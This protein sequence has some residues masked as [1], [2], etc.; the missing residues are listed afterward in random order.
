MFDILFKNIC[1]VNPEVDCPVIANAYVGVRDGKIAYLS[2]TETQDIAARVI[3][4]TDKALI[5]GL[6]NTHTHAAM[7][8]LRGYADDHN[9]QDWLH[10]YVFPAE[11]KLDEECVY[12]GTQLAIAEMIR[13]GTVSITDMY[14]YIPA[15][16]KAAYETG[17]YANITN[18]ALVFDRDGYR[19]EKDNSYIQMEQLRRDWHNIDNGRIKLDSGIHAE[20]TSFERVWRDYADYAKQYGLNM[21]LHLSETKFEHDSC[22][23]KYG[24]TPARVLCDAGVFDTRTTAAHCVWLTLEDMDILRDKGVT[25]AHNPV[26]NLKLA[27]GIARVSDMLSRGVNVAL[28]TDGVCSNNSHDMFE[29][30]KLCALLQKG[31]TLDP[32]CVNAC[33]AL[34]LATTAG[35]YAQGR[36]NSLGL[37]K[38]GFD[39]SMAMID[40]DVPQ[41]TPVHNPLSTVV[42][43]AS[44]R[45]VCM[46]MVRGKV[47][48]EN[49]EFITIDMD[50][51]KSRL[52]GYV[53]PRVFGIH[54]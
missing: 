46:T 29:E 33:Q 23:Q 26:S 34:S 21:Q 50:K 51:I 6:V 52:Y 42:Y 25:V 3:D 5:P 37:I 8:V 19:M 39:A 53:M 30:M 40:L 41:L 31:T 45:D 13:T 16:A 2:Q 38:V 54:R 7:S 44:G 43:S 15:V 1:V 32:K 48:Y 9:L 47:L 28:G 10:N 24:K 4:G 36:E 20:Y 12:V 27:S 22:I 17:I 11:A 14:M 18:A 49:G 35:A